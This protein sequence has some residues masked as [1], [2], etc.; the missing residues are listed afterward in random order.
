M[1]EIKLNLRE[2]AVDGLPEKSGDYIILKK[3]LNGY[4]ANT[5]S[6]SERHQAFNTSDYQETDQT[7][8]DGIT[9]WMPLD[10]F[11]AALNGGETP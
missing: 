3:R 2:V 4:N 11:N 6:F 1:K 7:R 5:Y 10:E 9:H 8:I